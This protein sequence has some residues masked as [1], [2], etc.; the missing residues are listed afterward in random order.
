M[1]SYVKQLNSFRFVSC[2]LHLLDFQ[3]GRIMIELRV[4]M[5][6]VGM[7]E[8]LLIYQ[9]SAIFFQIVCFMVSAKQVVITFQQEGDL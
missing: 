8:S 7:S 6:A 2:L 1:Q 4:C 3:S 9:K 5:K